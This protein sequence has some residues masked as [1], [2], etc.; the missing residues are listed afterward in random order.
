MRTSSGSGWTLL[1]ALVVSL[2]L[3]GCMISD[4]SG[5]MP[6]K[7]PGVG[8][9]YSAPED[10]TYH[11]DS[12]FNWAIVLGRSALLLLL[13]LWL[14]FSVGGAVPRILAAALLAVSGWLLYDGLVTLTGYRVEVRIDS[15]LHVS[16]PPA[17]PMDIPWGTIDTLEVSGFEWQRA[18]VAPGFGPNP[19]P[20]KLPFTELPDWR[21]I[22]FTLTDGRSL[23]LDVERLSIEQRQSLLNAIV[24]YGRLAEEK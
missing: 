1:F 11:F 16:V 20:R 18:R 4:Q 6:Q 9:G 19:Q 22:S 24:R 5:Q 13:A 3:A 21:T 7:L 12:G 8:S 10:I 23:V 2:A 14:Y 15:G 17:E